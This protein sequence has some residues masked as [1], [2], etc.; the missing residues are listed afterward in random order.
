M[1][2]SLVAVCVL[3][4]LTISL[5]LPAVAAQNFTFHNPTGFSVWITF[6]EAGSGKNAKTLCL[7]P[8]STET[9]YKSSGGNFI[10][11]LKGEARKNSN[12]QNSGRI[13]HLRDN[14]VKSSGDIDKTIREHSNG[15]L[16]W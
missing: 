13:W 7:K 5:I 10:K 6:Y 14:N 12:C 9:W 8:Q 11:S 3:A 1:R 2:R 15:G 4:I 16:S